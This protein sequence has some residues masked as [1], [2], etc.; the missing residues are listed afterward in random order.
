MGHCRAQS[1]VPA[2]SWDSWMRRLEAAGILQEITNSKQR[3]YFYGKY[4][5]ILND[6]VAGKAG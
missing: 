3:T 6:G 2:L 5:H 1:S 4:L